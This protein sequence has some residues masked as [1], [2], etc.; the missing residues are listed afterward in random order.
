MT[1]MVSLWPRGH[2]SRFSE[3]YYIHV[4]HRDKKTVS[5]ALIYVIL[6]YVHTF[7]TAAI[8]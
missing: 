1:T 6:I 2:F 4:I 8:N 7:V 5:S 3:V